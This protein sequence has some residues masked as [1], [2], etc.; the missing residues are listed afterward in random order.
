MTFVLLSYFL[1]LLGLN[2]ISAEA[3]TFGKDSFSGWEY[4]YVHYSSPRRIA[5]AWIT[6]EL[7][8]NVAG[9]VYFDDMNIQIYRTRKQHNRGG[10]G[11][12]KGG[13]GGAI[14][15]IFFWWVCATQVF[16]DRV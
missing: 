13:G 9:L 16:K 7:G 6:L 11:G 2:T 10:G 8:S 3:Y 5:G 4:G 15:F 14:Q 12:L 1:Q